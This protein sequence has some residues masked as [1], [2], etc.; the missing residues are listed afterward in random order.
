MKSRTSF[1]NSIVLKW[2]HWS[3]A[4]KIEALKLF[5]PTW[6]SYKLTFV[7]SS[8]RPSVTSFSRDWLICFFWFLAQRCKM[9][10]P[11]MWRSPI[12]G[13]NFFPAENAGNMP[14]NPVFWHFLE[15]LSLVFPDFLLKDVYCRA[16]K[17]G[18]LQFLES[19]SIFYSSIFAPFVR[20]LFHSFTCL[21]FRSFAF[22]FVRFSGSFPLM[23]II[24]CSHLSNFHYQQVGPISIQLVC[25]SLD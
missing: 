13:K 22:S 15:I 14:E 19:Y 7:R 18:F 10:I 9:A 8:V 24:I 1:Y 17:T 11:K 6:R 2:R 23:S 12:F 16:G 21:F 5:G 20:S 4:L 25:F 3:A